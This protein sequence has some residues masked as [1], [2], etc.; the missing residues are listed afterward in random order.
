MAA[1]AE[2]ALVRRFWALYQA[3]RWAEAE[4]LLS[5]TAH[6]LWWSTRE[7]FVGAS[8][9]V[10][11]NAVYPEGWTIRLLELNSLAPQR[12][13]SL[14][15]VDHDGAAFYANSFFEL[16][17]GPDGGRIASLD[18]YWSDGR[19]APAWRVPGELPGL[20]V[21]PPDERPGLD[22]SLV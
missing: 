17:G 6:C 12:V 10:H 2:L 14:V 3:R 15:R 5:P 11:V 16:E 9:I 21:F 19:P 22:L 8:T 13:H 4:A 20:Q 1:E 18:E 7:R